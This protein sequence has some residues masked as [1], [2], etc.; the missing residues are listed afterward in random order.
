[1]NEK[2]WC[3]KNQAIQILTIICLSLQELGIEKTEE[4]C[5]GELF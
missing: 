5:E 2:R 3:I 4:K 1:M